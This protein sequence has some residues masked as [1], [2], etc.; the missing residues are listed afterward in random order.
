MYMS[1]RQDYGHLIT[2]KEYG[3]AV[4]HPTSDMTQQDGVWERSYS[5]GLTLVNPAASSATVTLPDGTWVDVNGNTVGPTV[6][7]DG[8]TAQVLLKG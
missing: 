6:T 4:G 7:L 2:F 3:I 8:Q 1:G 5:N